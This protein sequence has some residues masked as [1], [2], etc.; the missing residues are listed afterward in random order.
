MR[1][2]LFLA[3][4]CANVTSDGKLRVMWI[5]RLKLIDRLLVQK[6]EGKK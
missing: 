2:L 3:A 6:K 5:L 4:D 1:L